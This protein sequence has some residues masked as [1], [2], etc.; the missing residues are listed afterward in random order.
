MEYSIINLI[1]LHPFADLPCD[2]KPILDI[3]LYPSVELAR[4]AELKKRVPRK[5]AVGMKKVFDYI[6]RCPIAVF[7]SADRYMR[8][9]GK[10]GAAS[11]RDIALAITICDTDRRELIED[12]RLYKALGRSKYSGHIESVFTSTRGTFA[13]QEQALVILNSLSGCSLFYADNIRR[14]L[15]M[16]KKDKIDEF[17]HAFLFGGVDENGTFPGCAQ[18]DRLTVGRNIWAEMRETVPKLQ[19]KAHVLSKAQLFVECAKLQML[20]GE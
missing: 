14:A 6:R 9:I 13:Y 7:D 18:N 12:I 5:S 15:A 10:I 3:L 8:A 19:L 1:T 16:R 20:C 2:G 4:Y 11:V 17:E